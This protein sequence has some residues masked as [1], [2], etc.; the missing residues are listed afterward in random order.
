MAHAARAKVHC[1]CRHGHGQDEDEEGGC[2]INAADEKGL[3]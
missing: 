2:S 1:R 3:F